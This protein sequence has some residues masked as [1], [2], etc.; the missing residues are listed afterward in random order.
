MSVE[1]LQRAVSVLR[2]HAEHAT[3][4]PWVAERDPDEL[5]WVMLRAADQDGERQGEVASLWDPVAEDDIPNFDYM[6][7]MHPPV[8]W[9]LALMIEAAI[10]YARLQD[11]E[12][13]EVYRAARDAACAVLRESV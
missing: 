7:L 8:A 11:A 12:D 9:A 6:A 3:S 10:P 1:L 2:E 13:F 5:R 4:G